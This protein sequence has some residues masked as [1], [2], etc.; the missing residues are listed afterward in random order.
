MHLVALWSQ[1]ANVKSRRSNV[2]VLWLRRLHELANPW[3]R[4][5]CLVIFLNPRLAKFRSQPLPLLGVSP[6][7]EAVFGVPPPR[8]AVVPR[9]CG[10]R[11]WSRFR[12]KHCCTSREVQSS[13]VIFFRFLLSACTRDPRLFSLCP[14]VEVFC[15]CLC[16]HPT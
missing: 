12:E 4:F 9:L 1:R 11:C 2:F 15:A 14:V 6:L 8:E 7:R 10:R 16:A 5:K 13:F 3:K